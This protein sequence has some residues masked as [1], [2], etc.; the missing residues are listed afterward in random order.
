MLVCV[1]RLSGCL[2][3]CRRGRSC[4]SQ[5]SSIRHP[6][7]RAA[8]SSN[9]RWIQTHY[10][11]TPST[12]QSTSGRGSGSCLSCV[13]TIY[14]ASY[15]AA[16]HRSQCPTKLEFAAAAALSVSPVFCV[17]ARQAACAVPCHASVASRSAVQAPTCGRFCRSQRAQ[18]LLYCCAVCCST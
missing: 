2:G 8:Y 13:K 4:W 15:R 12:A 11:S 18:R 9:Q 3:C 16:M 17:C 7:G 6:G 5:C 10:A 14:M 1:C